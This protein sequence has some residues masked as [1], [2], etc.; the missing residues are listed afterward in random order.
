VIQERRRFRRQS[1]PTVQHIA[2]SAEDLVAGRNLTP[3]VCH[4]L[5]RG[6]I[7]FLCQGMP[8]QR[9]FSFALQSGD[10]KLLF[11][12][13]VRHS[14]P[15]PYPSTLVVVGCEFTKRLDTL[16]HF[17]RPSLCHV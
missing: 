16:E 9:R 3:V 6:G 15:C 1:F 12:A 17:S 4:D 7:S 8:R 13:E 14:R 11:I 10:A 2:M 5:S